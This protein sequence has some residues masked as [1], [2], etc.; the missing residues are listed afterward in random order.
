MRFSEQGAEKRKQIIGKL[1]NK[2]KNTHKHKMS[3]THSE[4]KVN[5]LWLCFWLKAKWTL[6]PHLPCCYECVSRVITACP[7]TGLHSVQVTRPVR[8]SWLGASVDSEIES[9]GTYRKNLKASRFGPTGCWWE[10]LTAESWPIDAVGQNS[11]LGAAVVEMWC[12]KSK[13]LLTINDALW[14]KHTQGLFHQP[15]PCVHEL[16][17]PS[18]SQLEK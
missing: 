7:I 4:L 1:T 16:W 3:H 6:L 5:A 15:L 12:V 9:G 14:E 2:K 8:F 10:K 17:W 13:H 18:L 11:R